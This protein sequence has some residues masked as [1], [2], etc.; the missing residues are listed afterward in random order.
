MPKSPPG[1]HHV[2]R[3][4]L[5]IAAAL[6][7]S[8][9]G[10]IHVSQRAWDNGRAMTSSRQYQEIMAGSVNQRTLHALYL[11]SNPLS[12]LQRDLPYAPFGNWN[13]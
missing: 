8:T 4:L 6:L 1:R 12:A 13:W 7:A 10:C 11:R 2:S 5:L 9:T 3:T